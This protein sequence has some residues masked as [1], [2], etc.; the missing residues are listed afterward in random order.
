M[1]LN[2]ASAGRGSHGEEEDWSGSVR[3]ELTGWGRSI[4]FPEMCSRS[5]KDVFSYCPN[6]LDFRSFYCENSGQ[7]ITSSKSL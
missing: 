1:S 6:N 7:V 3:S 5:V 4:H 2:R